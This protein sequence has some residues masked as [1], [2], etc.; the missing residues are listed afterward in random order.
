MAELDHQ[1]LQQVLVEGVVVGDQHTQRSRLDHPRLFLPRASAADLDED[2][3]QRPRRDRLGQHRLDHTTVGGGRLRRGR[4]RGRDQNDRHLVCPA[5]AAQGGRDLEAVDRRRAVLDQGDVEWPPDLDCPLRLGWRGGGG[6]GAP[7]LD[8][9]GEDALLGR[10]GGDDEHS[11][12]LERQQ[13]RADTAGQGLG[14]DREPEGRARVRTRL[15]PALLDAKLAIHHL[16]EMLGGVEAEHR[17]PVAGLEAVVR[18]GHPVDPSAKNARG[19]AA[20]GVADPEVERDQAAA[21]L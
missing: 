12:R 20:A 11:H 2:V 7:L 10:V 8:L 6:A 4:R 3:V 17:Q 16:D 18:S 13:G 9:E 15:H 5:R 1:S 19:H 21:I 14:Q